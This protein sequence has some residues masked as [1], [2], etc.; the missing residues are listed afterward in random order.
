MVGIRDGQGIRRFVIATTV[1]H[2]LLAAWV[3]SDAARRGDIAPV[4]SIGVLIT[5]LIGLVPYLALR[6]PPPRS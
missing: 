2:V 5:G 3:G 6:R 1:I 4:W